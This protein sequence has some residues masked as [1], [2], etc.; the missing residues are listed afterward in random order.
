MNGDVGTKARDFG[1]KVAAR[2]VGVPLDYSLREL[3]RAE[4][5]AQDNGRADKVFTEAAAVLRE[6]FP[7]LRQESRARIQEIAARNHA[8][9][10]EALGKTGAN[11]TPR[12]SN[13]WKTLAHAITGE[14]HVRKSEPCEDAYSIATKGPALAMVVCDGASTAKHSKF[15]AEFVSKT[16][17]DNLL[18]IVADGNGVPDNPDHKAFAYAA[19]MTRQFLKNAAGQ[20]GIRDFGDLSCT[21]VACV[22][23]PERAALLH[24]GDGFGYVAGQ[25]RSRAIFSEPANG[26]TDSHTFFLCQESWQGNLRVQTLAKPDLICLG[27]DGARFTLNKDRSNVYEELVDDMHDIMFSKIKTP[28]RREQFLQNMMARHAKYA[29]G[30]DL[31]LAWA[32]LEQIERP[33]IM[34]SHSPDDPQVR[35]PEYRPTRTL[36]RW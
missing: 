4:Q 7:R 9:R 15:A 26:I 35:K 25:D 14:S 5:K 34:R 20:K 13:P 22:A 17:A 27:T 33:K 31:T 24:I 28:E 10:A 32:G 18:T 12:I 30:D 36:S 3:E 21:M 19:F 29:Y 2:I 1:L 16:M 11:D 8:R 23:T 6:E